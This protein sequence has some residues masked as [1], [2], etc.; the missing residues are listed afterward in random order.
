MATSVSKYRKLLLAFTL[1][2]GLAKAEELQPV[3]IPDSFVLPIESAQLHRRYEAFVRI[4]PGYD[5][6]ENRNRSYPVLYVTDASYTFPV[7]SGVTTV[8]FRFGLFREFIL[9]GISNAVGEPPMQARSRDL[10]PWLDN[11]FPDQPTGEAAQFLAF[12]KTELMPGVE[13]RF[14]VDPHRRVLSGQSYGGLFGL[15][16]AFTEPDLFEGYLLSSPS[17]WFAHRAIF[18][19]EADYAQAHKDLEARIYLTA[20]QLEPRMVED[21]DRLAKTLR[22]RKYPNLVVRT[23]VSVGTYH[24]TTYPIGLVR[25]LQWMFLKK[26]Q[27][28]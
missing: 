3:T 28:Q 7:A 19:A 6:P 1:F 15:W 18:K 17:I 21:I 26:G 14:R 4:P 10:T 20:G 2:G 11:T 13:T 9:V 12:L 5:L 25:G 24:E 23:E 27:Q 8:P 16:I 22:A